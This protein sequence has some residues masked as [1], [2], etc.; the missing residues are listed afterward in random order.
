MDKFTLYVPNFL[1]FREFF[2]PEKNTACPGCGLALAVRQ[3]YK[4][5]EKDIEK[6]VWEKP[7]QGKLFEKMFAKSPVGN[8]EPSLLRIKKAKAELMLCLDNEAGG[9]LEEA[10]KKSMP[11]IAVA[12][13]FQ[14]VAT[15]CP[16]YPF[17]LYE[18]VKKGMEVAGRAYIHIL[19][20]CPVGWQFDQELTVKIGRWAVEC[21]AFP[22]FE[23]SGGA[24]YHLTVKTQKPRSLAD[25]L[26]QQYR[27]GEL[28]DKQIEDA[29]IAV[30]NDY[31]KLIEKVQPE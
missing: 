5:L 24:A 28:S 25:Y 4:A 30:D 16:S 14:Y 9:S 7:A 13:G 3:I 1:P 11:A 17:D 18:K 15:A 12:E 6:A 26:K 10:I 31:K 21:R 8:S 29:A 23:V 2:V 22:L 20:P 27:F 19:C